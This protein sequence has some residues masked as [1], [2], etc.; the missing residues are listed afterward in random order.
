MARTRA[1]E[2]TDAGV[3]AL[4][5]RIGIA[6]PHPQPPHYLSPNED[7]FRH[8]AEAYGDDNPLWSDAAYAAGTRWAG[9]IAPPH[10]VGGDTMI[11]EDE[12][13]RL[14]AETKKALEG[15]PLRGVHA[16]YAGSFRE[17][18]RP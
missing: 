10:L 17:W 13:G 5:Q 1:G 6:Q 2:I 12:V 14:D 9:V 4:R 18:W 3:E 7:A 11:G 8:V 16:Y 15:D